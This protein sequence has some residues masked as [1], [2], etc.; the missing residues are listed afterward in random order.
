MATGLAIAILVIGAVLGVAQVALARARSGA[1]AAA[2]VGLVG[3]LTALWCAAYA[4]EVAASGEETVVLL[5]RVQWAAVAFIPLAMFMSALAFRGDRLPAREL[6]ALAVPGAI[7][8][9]LAWTND[10]HHLLWTRIELEPGHDTYTFT[11]GPAYVLFVVFAYLLLTAGTAMVVAAVR[12]LPARR[13]SLMPLVLVAIGLPWVANLAFH[14]G[15]RP[16]D[17][18]FTP[19]ALSLTGMLMTYGILR[20]RILDVFRG[21]TP[22]GRDATVRLMADGVVVVDR[23][24]NVADANPA[25][26]ALAGRAPRE[27]LGIPAVS[28]FPDWPA[29]VLAGTGDEPAVVTASA[30]AGRTLE[31]TVSPLRARGG[32]ATGRIIVVRDVT[33]RV[34][35]ERAL[36]TSE[37]RYRELVENASD[38]VFAAEAGGR[39]IALNR[40]G[41][42]LLGVGA[43]AL[44]AGEI[45]GGGPG[46]A[47]PE[48]LLDRLRRHGRATT[49]VEIAAA[50]GRQVAL[51]MSVRLMGAP[52]D[53]L[54]EGIGRDVTERRSWEQRLTWRALHDPLTEL[55]NRT[56]VRDRLEQA[57]RAAARDG[58]HMALLLIDLDHFKDVNDT[59]GHSVGD[60]VLGTIGERLQPHLREADTLGRLGGDEFAVVLPG[61]NEDVARLVAHRL[62]AAIEQPFVVDDNAFALGGS[63]GVAMGGGREVDCDELLRRADTAMYR[64]KATRR[65]VVAWS[66][67][68]DH[69]PLGRLGLREALRSAV[70]HGQLELHYQPQVRIGDGSVAAVEALVRWHHPERG[71]LRPAAFI[72]LAE[73]L[74]VIDEV[75]RW[76]VDRALRD[77]ADWRAAGR[78]VRVAVNLSPRT[79]ERGDGLAE[80]LRDALAETQAD[81]SW[82][83]VELTESAVVDDLERGGRLLGEISGLG[84]AVSI[85]DFG[86]GYSSLAHLRRLPV[87]ELKVDRLFVRDMGDDG[88]EAIVRSVIALGHHLGLAVVAEGIED[89]ATWNV[90]ERLG[91]DLG[92]GFHVSPPLPAAA[93]LAWIEERDALTARA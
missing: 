22:A 81:P 18:D 30:P 37:R 52:G 86:V 43:D 16:A 6:G 84:V 73:Q 35:A 65:S 62:L 82:L 1:P 57:L 8:L 31:I 74:G 90:L 40:A 42:V 17:V 34:H 32:V 25:A 59:L 38:V 71:L 79:L 48:A 5:A 53:G 47:V 56:L 45:L 36:H 67:V 68:L 27:V 9:T 28:A 69:G 14:L 50:D 83:K 41:R 39:V 15:V 80:F 78:H 87:S 49:D 77:C 61:A 26:C 19:V 89:L 24:G 33:D 58:G 93:L 2:W 70:E 88:D 54:V 11:P 92:Q 66:T 21:L 60:R 64:A 4:L 91:C 63:V 29:E 3:G 85:D 12:A 44:T 46:G 10:A 20:L 75:T 76:V 23:H 55:P 13:R 7:A 72:P 51:E